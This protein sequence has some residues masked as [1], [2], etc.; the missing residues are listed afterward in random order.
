MFANEYR[1]RAIRSTTAAGPRS[2]S[3]PGSPGCSHRRFGIEGGVR[4]FFMDVERSPSFP[5][6]RHHQRRPRGRPRDVPLLGPA[7]ATRV[8]TMR[9]S[10]RPDVALGGS[11][12]VLVAIAALAQAC[13]GSSSQQHAAPARQ[14]RS[15]SRFSQVKGSRPRRC[16]P[17]GCQSVEHHHPARTGKTV[18]GQ[19]HDR[20]PPPPGRPAQ[21][22]RRPA[23]AAARTSPRTSPIPV[24][25]VPPGLQSIEVALVFG[26]VNVTL[27]VQVSGGVQVTGSGI[28]CPA[29]APRASSAGT[30][31]KLTANQPDRRLHRRLQRH[32]L[33]HRPDEPATRPCSW[34]HPPRRMVSSGWTTSIRS[35]ATI[36]RPH[37][38]RPGRRRPRRR[39]IRPSRRQGL[40]RESPR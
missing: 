23:T 8:V 17:Q 10:S 28:A 5:Q 26:G 2:P 7:R 11:R 1:R 33:L 22:Q 12:V 20:L 21:R 36:G 24:F 39:T 38:R 3:G 14:P 6:A 40:A 31:V 30:S 34:R 35:A 4:Y 37:R 9:E 27:S 19:R 15:S 25:T 18:D 16:S 29:T 13:G 32:R